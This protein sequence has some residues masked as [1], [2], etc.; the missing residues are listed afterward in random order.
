MAATHVVRRTLQTGGRRLR[1]GETVDASGWK[2][3][4]RLVSLG[5]VSPIAESEKPRVRRGSADGGS[6]ETEP[7]L[8]ELNDLAD[9]AETQGAESEPS[10]LETAE[11]LGPL[12]GQ[13][14]DTDPGHGQASSPG[15]VPPAETR[16]GPGR[17]RKA[18][19]TE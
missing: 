3:L 5:Y 12:T 6:A 10:A 1:I 2:K 11:G 17:P 13:A 15:P 18:E 4:D 16:R 9:R 7:S 19:N 8:A 14:G